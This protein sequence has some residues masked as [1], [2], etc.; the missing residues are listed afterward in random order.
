MP[1]GK[2]EQSEPAQLT[3]IPLN[4]IE[5]HPKL[6][7]RFSY[8]IEGL[9]ES[10]MAAADENTPNGQLNPGRVVLKPGGE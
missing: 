2:G 4:L 6:A 3:T 8:D 5:P 1:R 10:I 7:F 9:A